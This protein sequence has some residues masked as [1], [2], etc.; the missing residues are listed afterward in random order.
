MRAVLA[1]LGLLG[2]STRTAIFGYLVVSAVGSVALWFLA[3]GAFRDE[4][5]RGA[6]VPMALLPDWVLY[7]QGAFALAL[8]WLSVRRFHDQDRPGWIALVPYAASALVWVGLP[9]SLGGL[10]WLAFLVGLVLPPTIG[11][12]RF[13][14]DPR[15]WKSRDHYLQ[16]RR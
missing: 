3:L 2:R 11:P 15:G 4:V 9:E 8:L 13:G 16:Q 6:T 10:V 5:R 7:V 14:P 12:N 1:R